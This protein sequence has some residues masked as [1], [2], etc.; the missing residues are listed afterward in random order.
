MTIDW[1]LFSFNTAIAAVVGGCML[2]I[3]A[4]WLAWANGRI[5]GI[6]GIV[7]H[8]VDL[9]VQRKHEMFGWRVA[10]LVGLV[11]APVLWQMFAVMPPVHEQTNTLGLVIGGML[12]GLGTRYGNGCTTG[13]GICGLS[14]FSLR[15][16][17]AVCSFMGSGIV[18]VYVIR[19][20]IGGG[21]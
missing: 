9:L 4:V 5:A 12:I 11:A 2:G 20:V 17:L 19:H 8:L 15:S 13:H 10:F 1:Q 7:G 16:L 14:R 3:S 6:S 18:T 21:A